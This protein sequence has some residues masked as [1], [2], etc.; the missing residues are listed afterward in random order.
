MKVPL[1]CNTT[2]TT[3]LTSTTMLAS[4]RS[5]RWVMFRLLFPRSDM[6][7]KT[8]LNHSCAEPER[9]IS[10]TSSGS[11]GAHL[12][13][14]AMFSIRNLTTVIICLLLLCK[15]KSA[16]PSVMWRILCVRGKVELSFID[17]YVWCA[18]CPS[19]I[20]TVPFGLHVNSPIRP[21]NNHKVVRSCF[22]PAC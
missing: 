12:L 4:K 14:L 2:H 8:A 11:L 1:R 20:R 17:C 15:A 18:F 22:L 19:N 6:Y 21:P 10:N 5:T 9:Y 16:F 7:S 13:L 3:S